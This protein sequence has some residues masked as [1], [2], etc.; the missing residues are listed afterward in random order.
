MPWGCSPARQAQ[1]AARDDA[2]KKYE[3]AINLLGRTRFA[4]QLAR[5]HL[6]YGEWLRRQRRRRE[7]RDQLRTAHD[8]FDAMGLHPFAERRSIE[9]RATGERARKREIGTPRS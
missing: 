2:R 4:P 5:A 3:E 9:L 6:L 1:L 7:A 8:M